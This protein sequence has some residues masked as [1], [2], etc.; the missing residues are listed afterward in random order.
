MTLGSFLHNY[1]T[2]IK[3]AFDAF[4]HDLAITLDQCAGP[5]LAADPQVL[6]CGRQLLINI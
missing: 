5:R 4:A 2:G 3:G 6:H 1:K